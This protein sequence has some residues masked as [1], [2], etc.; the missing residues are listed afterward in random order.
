MKSLNVVLCLVVALASLAVAQAP[1]DA[2]RGEALLRQAECLDCHTF[3]NAGKGTAP[4]LSRRT[5]EAFTRTQFAALMWNHAPSMW[6]MMHT[7]GKTVPTLGVD[8]VGDLFAY[9][10]SARFFEPTGDAGRGKQVFEARRCSVCHD[11]RTQKVGPP[12]AEWKEVTDPAGWI[13]QM[14]NHSGAMYAKAKEKKIA[15]PNLT[16]QEFSD[17]LVYLKGLPETRSFQA[18]FSLSDPQEGKVL[19]DKKGCTHCHVI[20]GQ[21]ANKIS[22]PINGRPADS[23]AAVA[24][25]MWNHAPRM[26]ES[27]KGD[28]PHFEGGEMNH[29]LAYLFWAGFFDEPGDPRA[30]QR[31]YE[32]RCA[33]CHAKGEAGAPD[34][35]F[36]RGRPGAAGERGASAISVTSALWKHGPKMLQALKSRGREWPV[37]QGSEMADLIAYLNQK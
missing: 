33:E 8:Q 17:L 35:A 32:K 36:L 23:L 20:H 25:M 14:W 18:Q 26:N 16:G 2:R 30:G 37:F 11:L 7:G 21:E 4:D 12:V 31:V 29:V 13:R 6:G 1:G 24:A 10:Y 15:W 22:I 19:F 27:A 28:L 34:L 3:A 5:A 9:F